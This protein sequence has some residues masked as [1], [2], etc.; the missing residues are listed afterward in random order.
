MTPGTFH[1]AARD[2]SW[3]P[4]FVLPQETLDQTRLVLPL[5][6][7]RGAAGDLRPAPLRCGKNSGTMDSFNSA[8]EIQTLWGLVEQESLCVL[9]TVTCVA[10]STFPV[11]EQQIL[12]PF[13]R[14]G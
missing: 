7:A 2:L 11:H 12:L 13:S 1:L 10:S 4:G 8:A 6:R 3:H 14:I 5:P 9:R